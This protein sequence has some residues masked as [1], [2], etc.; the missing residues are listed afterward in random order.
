MRAAPALVGSSDDGDAVFE[1]VI[2]RHGLMTGG[3]DHHRLR[4]FT[5][6]VI[7]RRGAPRHLKIENSVLDPVAAH[8]LVHDANERRARHRHR[9]IELAER[10]LEPVEVARLVEA[11]SGDHGD[12]LV[13]SIGELE[14]AILDMNRGVAMGQIAAVDVGDA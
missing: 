12:N 2:G 5:P 4:P 7:A 1:V 8:D 14:A 10:A 3:H 6:C 13:N 11:P 9:D